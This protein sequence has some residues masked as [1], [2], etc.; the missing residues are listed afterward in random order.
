MKLTFISDTHSLHDRMPPLASGDVLMHC[1]DFTGRGTL[2][3]TQHFAE[4]IAAQDFTHKIVIAGNH[5]TCFED[6]RK[7]EAEA[8]LRDNGIIYLNDSGV[9]I[10]GVKFWGSPVQPEFFNWSFNRQRGADIRRHWEKIPVDT[11]VLITHGPPRHILDRCENGF[12]A[13]CDDLLEV[14][15]RIKPDIHAFGHIHEAYGVLEAG[16]TTFINACILDERYRVVNPP[17]E[18]EW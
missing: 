11:N 18:V 2:E 3:D 14:I 5:D 1:G 7:D 17:V 16:G 4:F 9:E 12:P 15:Q 10:A 13:G 6:Q 8:C